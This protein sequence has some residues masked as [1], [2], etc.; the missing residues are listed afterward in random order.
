MITQDQ[1]VES[2]GFIAG[3]Y[4]QN[5]NTALVTGTGLG[6]L[7]RDVAHQIV[8]PYRAVPNFPA[9]SVPFHA[10][11]FVIGELYGAAVIVMDGR[12]HYYEGLSMCLLT[13]PVRVLHQLG[14]RNLILTNAA[15]SLKQQLVPG[16]LAV[17]E[18]HLNLMG[19]NPLRGISKDLCK[20]RFVDMSEPYSRQ[21]IDKT[22]KTASRLGLSLQETIYAAISG[23]ALLTPAEVNML[24]FF[25]ADT[26]GMSTVPEV[27]VARQLGMNVLALS[28]ITDSSLPGL[29]STIN[30]KQVSAAAQQCTA[31]LKR[32]LIHIINNINES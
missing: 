29:G 3:Q 32:L 14:I 4:Q 25:G 19:D 23:P 12:Y 10:A 5:I 6:G 17:I 13:L 21:W 15:S 22:L 28:A 16:S 24:Q 27:I 7:T 20:E 2:A 31:Q 9:S 11:R 1:V 8:I 30:R 26:V 18:D